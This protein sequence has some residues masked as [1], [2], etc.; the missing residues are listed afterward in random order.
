MPFLIRCIDKPGSAEL[1]AATRAEHLA[2]LE[3]QLPRILAAGA[4]LDDAG[5]PTGSLILFDSEDRAEAERFAG[6]DPYNR[7]GLFA[8]VDV[9]RWRKVIFDGKTC[10]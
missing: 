4:V 2:Y 3:P 9:A 1:R 8:T 6:E 10:A 5:S 7:A